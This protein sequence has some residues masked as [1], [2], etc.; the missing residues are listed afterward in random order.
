MSFLA[1]FNRRVPA[2]ERG[3]HSPSDFHTTRAGAWQHGRL[4][5]A[6]SRLPATTTASTAATAADTGVTQ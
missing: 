6:T 5:A 4:A 2:D 3:S 1:S